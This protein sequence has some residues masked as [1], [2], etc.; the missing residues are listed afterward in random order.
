MSRL[1]EL[2]SVSVDFG[3]R[4]Q[5]KRA[6]DRVS[7]SVEA[8]KTV[9]L[10]GESGSGKTTIGKVLLGQVRADEG[11][12]RFDGEDITHF[13]NRERRRLS[14]RIQVVFQNPF[15][16]LNPQRTIGQTVAETLVT[17]RDLSQT[18]VRARVVQM[19]ERVGIQGEAI[20][21]YP[22]SFS[23]GQ[24]QRIAIARALLPNPELLICDEAVSALDL[25]IQAQVLNLLIELQES[26]GLACLFITHDIS[27]V[28]HLCHE[29]VVLR[30]G[31]VMESGD[32]ESVCSTPQSDYTERLLAAAPIPDPAAQALAREARL[33]R[34]RIDLTTNK[35]SQ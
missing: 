19:L 12:V 11:A 15:L 29:V 17:R 7:F 27:V 33:E 5:V 9:G 32:T 3:R 18:E 23:G 8:G 1:L 21:R 16:S 2:E 26:L 20:D 34:Q 31:V 4:G 22:A 35:E 30:H 24:R 13:R 6:L 25:S 10:V 28:R 14:S